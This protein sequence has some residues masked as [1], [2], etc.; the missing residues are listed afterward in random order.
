M[1]R[2]ITD[3]IIL[4]HRY[5]F[6]TSASLM[7]NMPAAEYAVARA[8]AFP[9][10]A[11]GL[12]LNICQGRPLLP[13]SEVSSLVGADG[14]FHPPREMA[15]RLWTQRAAP[16]EI[17]REFRE[18]ILWMKGR[19]LPPSHA[20]SHHHM[21]L[22]PAAAR[23]FARA[24]AAEAIPCARSCRCTEWPK[25][26][27]I[28]GPYGGGVVRR[29]CVQ[30]YRRALQRTILRRFGSPDSRVAISLGSAPRSVDLRD[31]W[32]TTLE[33]LPP[34]TFELSCHP[35]LFERGFS[36]GDAIRMRREEE[37]LC[38]ADHDVRG[39]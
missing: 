36:E 27:A 21:H 24:L 34:G 4:A 32:K 20:D 17:E 29:V 10:L 1:S 2:G 19:G 6:L 9:R 5:G 14:N 11:V 30:A 8:R 16:A 18:Q 23:A 26:R 33:N 13:A 31:R 25:G 37:L 22:Y 3:G 39:V 15:R 38:L 28:G 12:H 35:G 7:A